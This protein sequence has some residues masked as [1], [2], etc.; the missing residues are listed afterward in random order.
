MNDSLR[1]EKGGKTY[2][3]P[4]RSIEGHIAVIID[5][6]KMTAVTIP[7]VREVCAQRGQILVFA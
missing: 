4:C 2:L 5:A 6:S 3:V 1:V 7:E